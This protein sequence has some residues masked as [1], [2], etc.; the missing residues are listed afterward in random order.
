MIVFPLGGEKCEHLGFPTNVLHYSVS[1][2]ARFIYVIGK[3][4]RGLSQIYVW[5]LH[6]G[7]RQ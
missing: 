6:R 4:F 2:D 1:P 7:I 5:D 3:E